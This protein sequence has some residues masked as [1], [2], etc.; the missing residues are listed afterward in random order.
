MTED[1]IY[2]RLPQISEADGLQQL[3]TDIDRDCRGPARVVIDAWLTGP[4][5]CRIPAAFTCSSLHELAVGAMLERIDSVQPPLRVQFMESVIR[6]HRRQRELLLTVL[7][8]LLA[9]RQIVAPD[10]PS[11]PM[12]ACDLA[13]L[14][15]RRMVTAPRD[16]EGPFPSA[17]AFTALDADERLIE[18][19]RWLK[20]S[21]WQAL[22]PPT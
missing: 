6:Q 8:P 7:E 2:R 16:D 4:P 13:Y 1:E 9:D 14:I 17:E 11:G 18:I 22:F 21:V 10:H 20:S 15:V 3:A 12:R 19:L 5:E